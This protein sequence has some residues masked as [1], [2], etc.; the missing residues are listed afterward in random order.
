MGDRRLNTTRERDDHVAAVQVLLRRLAEA[1]S[2]YKASEI[3]DVSTEAQRLIRDLH[4]DLRG[5]EAS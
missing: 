2:G 1:P 4:T 3:R 5:W